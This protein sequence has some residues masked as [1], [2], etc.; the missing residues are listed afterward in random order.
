MNKEEHVEKLLTELELLGEILSY[1]KGHSAS[2]LRCWILESRELKKYV[3]D[4]Y[5]DDKKA[6]KELDTKLDRVII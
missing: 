3:L 6:E 4:L 2:Q 1:A 5:L